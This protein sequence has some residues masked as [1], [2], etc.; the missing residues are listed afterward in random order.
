MAVP[1]PVV[2]PASRPPSER[3]V[4]L[5]TSQPEL[6]ASNAKEKTSVARVTGTDLSFIAC[7]IAAFQFSPM[8][9]AIGIRQNV[10]RRL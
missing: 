1:P 8:H 3:D 9:H 4:V 7:L 6:V 5:L 2:D 10:M